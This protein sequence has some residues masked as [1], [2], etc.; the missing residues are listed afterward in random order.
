MCLIICNFIATIWYN[1]ENI[2]SIEEIIISRT[3][4]EK[5]F[6]MSIL[7]EKARDV[8]C[9]RYCEINRIKLN[10]FKYT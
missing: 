9:K 7:K 3:L 2:D 8:L 6:I 1:R 4:K 10:S 5:E